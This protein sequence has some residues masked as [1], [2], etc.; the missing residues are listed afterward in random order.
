M[1][2][3]DFI[4]NNHKKPSICFFI[5]WHIEVFSFHSM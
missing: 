4:V 1:V 5:Q 2:R 3:D